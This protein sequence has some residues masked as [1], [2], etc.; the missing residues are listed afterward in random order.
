MGYTLFM[1]TNSPLSAAPSLNKTLAYDPIKD[2]A[3]ITRIGSFTMMIAVNAQTPVKSISE[4]I[5]Y[6][7][8]NPGKLS[9]ASGN[10]AGIIAGETFKKWA[11]VD[12]LHVPYKTVPPA[13]NDV[14]GGRIPI[15]CTDLSPALPH[16]ASGALR[17]LASTRLRR[18]ALLPNVPTLDELG[19]S[20]VE[21]DAWAAL[22]APAGT[23]SEIINR[24]NS[25]VRK[26]I[27]DP[28]VKEQI[29]KLGF[30]AFTSTPGELDNF[31]GVQLDHWTKMIKD[32]GIQ[33]E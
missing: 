33:P 19:A 4:L 7:K 17:T 11:G 9:Y 26:I 13:L 28:Q 12:I 25:E 18:S 3:G 16:F 31:V 21:V 22:L 1:S 30:E 15:L 2:F 20:G 23:S 5:A 24:L 8:A 29:A 14:I 6:A 27:A 10:T 32:A